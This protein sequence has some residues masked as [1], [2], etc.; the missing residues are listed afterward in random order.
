MKKHL[1][2]FYCFCIFL[3]MSVSAQAATIDQY[4]WTQTLQRIFDSLRGPVAYT[5]AGI[6]IVVSGLVMAFTDL[7]GGA[8]RFIQAALGISIAFGSVT[9]LATLFTFS[10]AVIN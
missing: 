5:V 7:Q 2:R 10:G 1:S 8:K 3:L 6:A 4:A 9:I